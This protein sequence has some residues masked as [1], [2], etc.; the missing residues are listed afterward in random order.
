M[1][2][3]LFLYISPWNIHSI[4]ILDIGLCRCPEVSSTH[5]SSSLLGISLDSTIPRVQSHH[6]YLKINHCLFFHP[7]W[8]TH[9]YKNFSCENEAFPLWFVCSITLIKNNILSS[10]IGTVYMFAFN[11]LCSL[12]KFSLKICKD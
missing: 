6:L 8:K 1:L 9:P 2:Y 12:H 5:S 4:L 7:N 3:L 10:T 11:I